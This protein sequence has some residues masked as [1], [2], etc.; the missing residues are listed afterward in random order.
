MLQGTIGSGEQPQPKNGPR[1]DKRDR[2]TRIRIFEG[3][4]ALANG[5]GWPMFNMHLLAGM[6]NGWIIEW[7]LGMVAVGETL[8]TKGRSTGC[9]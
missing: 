5:G 1:W 4:R 6:M 8:F 9:S 2:L 7:H 3:L